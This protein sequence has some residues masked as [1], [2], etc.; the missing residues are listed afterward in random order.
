KLRGIEEGIAR[1]LLELQEKTEKSRQKLS[2]LETRLTVLVTEK[3]FE[4]IPKAGEAL[5]PDNQYF[6]LHDSRAKLEK[7]I[8]RTKSALKILNSQVEKY[9]EEDVEHSAEELT[10][11]HL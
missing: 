4:N 11:L 5:L 1:Q 9:K 8:E 6:Q 2:D 3:G 10:R 7:E